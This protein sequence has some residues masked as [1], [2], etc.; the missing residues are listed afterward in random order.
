M[1]ATEIHW[2]I[3][4]TIL[5]VLPALGSSGGVERGTVELAGAIV[6]AGGR[7]IVASVGGRRVHEL[8]RVGAKHVTIPLDSK[9]PVVMYNNIAR[10]SALVLQEDVNIIHARSR[11]PAWSAYFA[12]QRTDRAFVT[13]F[14]GVYNSNSFLKNYYNSIMTRGAR[15]IAIST[16]IAGHVRRV[17]GV[18]LERIR[19]VPRGVDTFQFNQAK[20][21]A[22]RI[23]NLAHE[24]RLEDGMPVVMLPGRL[25]R[26]KGHKVFIDAIARLGRRDLRCLI[27]GSD[28]GRKGYRHEL[29]SLIEENELGD[30]VR[31][32]DHCDDMP[33]AYMLSDIVV[34]AS[35]DPE[36][37]G[38]VIV[39]AQALG[40]P[41]IAS[42]H[43]GATENIIE[44]ETGWLVPPGQAIPLAEALSR[45]LDMAADERASLSKAAISNATQ[46][47]SKQVMCQ[48][49]L[50]IY[51]E[52][53]SERGWT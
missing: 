18:P 32:V 31:I 26:W 43:G 14:H 51:S 49:V 50:N 39:E 3:P 4:A 30:I 33:A 12:A 42:D 9:N 7:A 37:F 52:V 23:I 25:T 44:G 20:V 47:F 6:E 41:V 34:S 1:Q 53:L 13:T 22:E 24:W 16:F 28:Q 35:T 5:Q 8:T 27:V 40:R 21:S 45:I 10:L 2:D 19:I 38:R 15:V 46:N 17:Y 36:A 11:A 29:V 48:N